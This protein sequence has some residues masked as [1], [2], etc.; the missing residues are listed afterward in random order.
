MFNNP[1]SMVVAIVAIVSIASIVRARYGLH[2]H[3]HGHGRG[4]AA[5]PSM[6]DTEELA[7][8]RDEVRG[9][10]ERVAV[11]E[12]LATDSRSALE[13]EFEQLRREP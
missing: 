13:R 11:L 6:E 2:R 4:H 1:F 9:L 8:L 10:K 3:G 7:R 5:H 12:R